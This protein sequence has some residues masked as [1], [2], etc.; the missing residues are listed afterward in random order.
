MKKLNSELIY[1]LQLVHAPNVGIKTIR[2][3]VAQFKTVG[4]ICSASK[5]DLRAFKLNE[6]QIYAIKNPDEKLLLITDNWLNE[7]DRNHLIVFTEPDYPTL[8][9]QISSL[10]PIL[11]VSGDPK[12]LLSAQIAMVGSRNPSKTGLE[13]ATQF[14][15]ELAEKNMCVTSGLAL[16]IDTACHTGA[17]DASG[18]TIA[19]LGSG[20]HYI[21][22]KK[23]AALADK[24][25]EN[26]CLV[27][28]WPLSTPPKAENFPRRNR[29]ISGLSLGTVVI[30]A[31]LQSGSLITAHYATEQNREVF[32]LPGSIRNPMSTG[33][34][35]LIQQGAK[36]VTCVE[37]IIDELKPLLLQNTEP[38]IQKN[39]LN[40]SALEN[41][42]LDP[43]QQLVLACIE[44]EMTGVDQICERSKLSAQSVTA[45]LLMLELDGYIYSELGGY[46]RA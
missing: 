8:L 3:L 33:C 45:I 42:N 20:F 39:A 13:I 4:H 19:V 9:S 29:I 21:Y 7:S 32:A 35:A 10:P 41:L 5:A 15:F 31:A 34:L 28:E 26:G 44:G 27:S 16:G 12:L 36:C 6:A 23:N 1:W 43:E 17:L 22:P 11:Y 30:E 46:S 38:E 18:K 37:D 2:R 14:A 24:I 25:I 40:S